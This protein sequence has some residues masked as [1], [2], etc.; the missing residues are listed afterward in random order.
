LGQVSDIVDGILFLESSPFITGE[1]LTSTAA[2]AP[3]TDQ[4][5][6][7]RLGRAHPIAGT[8]APRHGKHELADGLAGEQLGQDI[9]TARTTSSTMSSRETS[10]RAS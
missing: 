8:V 3:A 1:I 9:G 10:R 5:S 4:A 2:R 6:G 7:G